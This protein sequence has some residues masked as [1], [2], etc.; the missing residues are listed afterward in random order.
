MAGIG[1]D[2]SYE[3]VDVPVGSAKNAVQ[4]LRAALRK[5]PEKGGA[6]QAGF[7]KEVQEHSLTPSRRSM[8]TQVNP[9]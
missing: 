3:V 7:E 1:S 4:V 2:G 9:G 5:R 6:R 8:Q